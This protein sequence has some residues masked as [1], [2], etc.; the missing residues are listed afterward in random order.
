MWRIGVITRALQKAAVTESRT[1]H[2]KTTPPSRTHEETSEFLP[3]LSDELI[4]PP[5][6]IHFPVGV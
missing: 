1:L 4:V 3:S 5:E 2:E 6:R